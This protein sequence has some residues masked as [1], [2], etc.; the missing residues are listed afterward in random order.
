[1]PRWHLRLTSLRTGLDIIIL[2]GHS[3]IAG[4]RVGH[5]SRSYWAI[6]YLTR[7]AG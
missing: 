5:R 2:A 6:S 4:Q 3:R 7:S 1:M